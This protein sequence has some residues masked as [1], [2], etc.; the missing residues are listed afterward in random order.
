M[1]VAVG[2]V[3]AGLAIGDGGGSGPDVA[4][5]EERSAPERQPSSPGTGSV[6]DGA[7]GPVLGQPTGAALLLQSSSG[8][9]SWVQLDSG[10]R[11]EVELT[12]RAARGL[13]PVPGGVVG[14]FGDVAEHWPLPGGEAV[15]LGEADLVV[16]G[17]TPGTVWL[18]RQ[19][20]D[21]P[22][23][24]G[25]DAVLVGLDAVRRSGPIDLEGAHPL[26]ATD[27][28]L[29]F[30]RGGRTY[31]AG[32]S[33]VRPVAD[34]EARATNTGA[35]VV[36][37]C[38]DAAVCAPAVVDVATGRARRISAVRTPP[39][40]G[41]TVLLT[42]DGRRLLVVSYAGQEAD[43]A[44]YDETGGL[45]GRVEGLVAGVE[46][47][48]LPDGRGLIAV[49]ARFGPVH[50]VLGLDGLGLVPITA[51]ARDQIAFLLVIPP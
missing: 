46:P 8:A 32:E 28:G 11:R 21:G 23:L 10:A 13:V 49:H 1:V 20:F 18:V 9:W 12:P 6:P 35:V 40:L 30:S 50:I 39:E 17:S 41:A 15:P 45:L 27:G 42:D 7:P 48:W 16:A 47:R 25:S 38:D 4:P 33:G 19:H 24:V 34:G 2:V 14:I 26:G 22:S 36:I 31:V 37:A 3:V 44:V 29:V 5:V 43:L 51:L